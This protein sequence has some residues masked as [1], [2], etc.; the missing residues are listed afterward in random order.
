MCQS[1]ISNQHVAGSSFF[2]SF[3]CCDDAL[4][5]IFAAEAKGEVTSMLPVMHMLIKKGVV[6]REPVVRKLV[7]AAAATCDAKLYGHT[8]F[9]TTLALG[10]TISATMVKSYPL[11]IAP[12]PVIEPEAAVEGEVAPVV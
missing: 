10:E 7:E 2:I 9:Y 3:A 8:I 6:M 11:A 5:M 12:E 4:R 1:C